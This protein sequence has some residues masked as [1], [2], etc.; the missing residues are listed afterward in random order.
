VRVLS[1]LALTLWLPLS[2]RSPVTLMALLHLLRSLAAS[3]VRI[4]KLS[5]SIRKDAL[6]RCVLVLPLMG[7]RFP[8]CFVAQADSV[9]AK[10]HS[11]NLGI[12]APGDFV[13][14][15]SEFLS[16]ESVTRQREPKLQH[17]LFYASARR[18]RRGYGELLQT[19]CLFR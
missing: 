17:S 15:E 9:W 18:L 7:F 10:L 13:C 3:R 16:P 4:P 19:F 2:R 12:D 1:L 6:T 5:P 14:G 11:N 8:V